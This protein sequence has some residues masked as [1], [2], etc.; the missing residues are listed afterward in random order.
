[1]GAGGG[2][3]IDGIGA[4]VVGAAAIATAVEPQLAGA[5][6]AAAEPQ[7]AGAAVACGWAPPPQDGAPGWF[8]TLEPQLAPGFAT[9]EPQLGP[10][11]AGC[12][13]VTG[14]AEIA[15]GF[16]NGMTLLAG[17]GIC[18][19]GAGMCAGAADIFGALADTADICCAGEREPVGA[20]GALRGFG[21]GS[22]EAGT[23]GLTDGEPGL[24]IFGSLGAR[25][26]STDVTSPIS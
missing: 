12:E 19:A 3:A 5:T 20:G 21:A 24:D 8:A 22:A 7:L 17:A 23:T 6:A 9:F 4:I 15:R 1:M 26:E 13:N 14:R 16:A 2:G 18:G 10:D 11:E 25:R